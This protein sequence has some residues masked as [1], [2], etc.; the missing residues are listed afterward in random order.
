MVKSHRDHKGISQERVANECGEATNRSAVAHLEQG[1]RLPKPEVL[2]AICQYLN[3]PN[4]YWEPF[5]RTESLLRFKFEELLSELVGRTVNLDMH[6]ETAQQTAEN[7]ISRIFQTNPSSDQLLD[8]FNSILVYYGAGPVKGDFFSRYFDP[9]SFGSPDAFQKALEKYQMDA[10][11]LFS[12]FAEAFETLN[13]AHDIEVVLQPIRRRPVT[14]YQGRTEWTEI[15]QI[16]DKLLPDLGYISA[17][18]VRQEVVEREWLIEQLR[19]LAASMKSDWSSATNM[20]TVKTCRKID[21]LLRKF[22]STIAHGVSSPLFQPDPDAL[23]READR[24]APRTEEE[25]ERMEVTQ[26]KAL[27]NL[28]RYLAADH[29]D[30]YVATSMR[31]DAD[32]VSVNN[33]VTTLF[34]HER[35]RPLKLRYFNPTQSWIDDRVAKGLIEALMLKRASVTIYMAQKSDTFGKDSEASVALGQGKPVVVYVPKLMLGD[36]IDSERLFNIGRGDLVQLYNALPGEDDADDTMD[37]EALIAGVLRAEVS[38][39]QEALLRACIRE[40]WAD[41]DLY[42]EA[43][44]F[45]AD[46]REIYRSWLDKVIGDGDETPLPPEI[47]D[48]L[49]GALVATTINFEKRARIFREVHPLA[50]QVILSTGVLNGILVTRTVEQCA[51]V[52]EAVIKNDLDLESQKDEDNY[53]VIERVTGSTIRVISRHELLRNAFEAHYRKSRGAAG[54]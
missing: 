26:H 19:S 4:P 54:N 33:F 23:A 17:K 9:L 35:I 42:A 22:D 48:P 32:Y 20:L 44:R 36:T 40:N 45:E 14:D 13:A 47:R 8:I 1:L 52:L 15:E 18:R 3:I 30:V 21:S 10:I 49:L 38:N 46:L 27:R 43:D 5:T 50:L 39:Q 29:L 51:K 34:T 37:D 2:R 7:M 53:R 25:L 24:L 11:R 6:D 16:E 28:S 31:T 41:F 12:T